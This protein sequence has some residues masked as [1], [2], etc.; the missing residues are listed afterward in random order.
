[1]LS[2]NELFKFFR[3]RLHV[4]KTVTERLANVTN[5][6]QRKFNYDSNEYVL[7]LSRMLMG[8]T[9]TTRTPSH[10][11]RLQLNVFNFKKNLLSIVGANEYGT[12]P[13]IFLG[14]FG[15]VRTKDERWKEEV[16]E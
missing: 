6:S 4:L 7:N 12:E 9:T 1:M 5:G 14:H 3:K 2:R 10:L 16:W 11:Q 15:S 8:A 13:V